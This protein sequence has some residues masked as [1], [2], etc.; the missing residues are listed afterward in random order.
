MRYGEILSELF[1][2]RVQYTWGQQTDTVWRAKFAVDGYEYNVRFKSEHDHTFGPGWDFAFAM[3][4]SSGAGAKFKDSGVD[5]V[6]I[7]STGKAPRVF[8]CVLQIMDD[9]IKQAEPTYVAFSAQEPSRRTLY[10]RMINTLLVQ[11]PKYKRVGDQGDDS[12]FIISRIP[13]HADI[14]DNGI[15]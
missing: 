9:F 10:R 13:E 14:S 7:L 12:L 5:T 6:G 4:F 11:Y 1:D 15:I 2:S 8:S 3:Q